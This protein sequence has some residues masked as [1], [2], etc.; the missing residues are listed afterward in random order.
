MKILTE[1]YF[2]GTG[3]DGK[4]P[5]PSLIDDI[6]ELPNTP[7]AF[8][9][10]LTKDN[11]QQFKKRLERI[12]RSA[13]Y[14]AYRG[15]S[16]CR[17]CGCRN[18]SVEFYINHYDKI[19]GDVQVRWPEGYIHYLKEHNLHPSEWFFNFVMF[20]EPVDDRFEYDKFYMSPALEIQE[21]KSLKEN[22]DKLAKQYTPE[23]IKQIVETASAKLKNIYVKQLIKEM[24]PYPY[25]SSVVE[26]FG[27]MNC[28]Q[29][30][31]TCRDA[32]AKIKNQKY[33]NADEMKDILTAAILAGKHDKLI[34]EIQ[35]AQHI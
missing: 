3:A 13:K 16:V 23:K 33:R 8:H 11:Y 30:T 35:K 5:P 26:K 6:D 15:S 2:K 14:D 34:E 32:G 20:R 1:G 7:G 12:Q 25:P 10:F 31:K 18:G 22:I 19:V 29:Q 9:G 17:V 4:Y 21:A 27:L 28:Q 24:K